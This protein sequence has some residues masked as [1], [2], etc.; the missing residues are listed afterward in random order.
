MLHHCGRCPIRVQP[1]RWG[2]AYFVPLCLDVEGREV[3]CKFYIGYAHLALSCRLSKRAEVNAS[4]GAGL[5]RSAVPG[6]DHGLAESEGQ[7]VVRDHAA[8]GGL[9]LFP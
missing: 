8:R 6:E 1:E 5:V 7:G 4:H 3:G 9:H 2:E